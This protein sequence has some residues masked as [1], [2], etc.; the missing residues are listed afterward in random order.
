MR[1]SPRH[2]APGSLS[3]A[4]NRQE[5]FSYLLLSLFHQD[6]RDAHTELSRHRNDG[7]S[8]SQV[9][10]MGPAHRAEKLSQLPVLT[11]RRPGGLDELTSKPPVSRVGDRSSIGSLSGRVLGRHQ[12][13]K[14]SQLTDIFKLSP[15]PDAS[16]KLTGH[17]PADPGNRHQILNALGQLGIVSAEAAD[18]SSRL[19]NLLLRKLQTVEQL[20]KLKSH[21]LRT[22]KLSQLVLDPERPLSAGGC[23]GK[24]D[25]FEEQQR[26]D[27]LLHAHHL[28][29]KRIAQL[30]QVTQLPVQS[31]GN[32]D[33]PEL[34]PTQV[35]RQS[36]TVKSIGLHSLSWS[37]GDHRWR[38]DQAGVG[39]RHQPII[40]SVPRRSSLVG[41]GHL[42]IA[43]VLAHMIHKM[44]H[45]IGHTQGTNKSLMIG[46]GHR[47]A[48][49][50]DVQSAKHLVIRRLECFAFH[51]CPS[52]AQRFSLQPLYRRTLDLA[53]HPSYKSHHERKSFNDQN[54]SVRSFE[55]LRTASEPCRRTPRVFSAACQEPCISSRQPPPRHRSPSSSPSARIQGLV[56]CATISTCSVCGNMSNGLNCATRYPAWTS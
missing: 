5:F 31:G 45:A 20:V 53:R 17:N 22:L 29:H 21:G 42:L 44:L 33:A 40:Q 37:F 12:A 41:K 34:S 38:G 51:R 16:H 43:K 39:F 28:A 7:H 6:H 25:P 15:I 55:K 9:A 48:P 14:P 52:L 4:P 11:D 56:S 46:E 49:L 27:A 54:T 36:P 19:Q 3:Q 8:R 35:L 10:R 32:M 2:K 23:R 47:D 26:F 18:L 24:L 50:V 30:S 1:P 13:E